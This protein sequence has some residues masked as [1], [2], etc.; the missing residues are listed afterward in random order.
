MD[1]EMIAPRGSI[2]NVTGSMCNGFNFYET[3]WSG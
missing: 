1:T 3:M 2:L